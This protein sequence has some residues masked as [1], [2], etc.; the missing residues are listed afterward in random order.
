MANS[1]LRKLNN[2]TNVNLMFFSCFVKHNF[3]QVWVEVHIALLIRG[4]KV[5]CYSNLNW[6][7]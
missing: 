5:P 1:G 4:E 3:V 7:V 6:K 2:S